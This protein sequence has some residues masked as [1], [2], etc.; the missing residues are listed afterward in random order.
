ML[1]TISPLKVA[2][3]ASSFVDLATWP[4]LKKYEHVANSPYV[5][6]DRRELFVELFGCLDF[7]HVVRNF[8]NDRAQSWDLS[9]ARQ[10]S[11]MEKLKILFLKK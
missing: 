7:L 10:S 5:A 9:H 6:L 4:W 8:S 2:L 11:D 3:G 1:L